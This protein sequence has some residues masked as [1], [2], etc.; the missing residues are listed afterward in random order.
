M[1]MKS[2][3]DKGARAMYPDKGEKVGMKLMA[4]VIRKYTLLTRKN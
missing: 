2:T 1:L 4:A 3:N